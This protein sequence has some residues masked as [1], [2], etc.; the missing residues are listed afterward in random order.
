MWNQARPIASQFPIYAV[1]TRC[2]TLKCQPEVIF[3]ASY[4]NGHYTQGAFPTAISGVGGAMF[5]QQWHPWPLSGNRPSRSARR[6]PA[7]L[8]ISF[9]RRL[10]FEPLEDRRLLASV[11]VSNNLDVVNGNTSSI[12][13]LIANDGI[14]LREAIL[15]ANATSECVVW[16]TAHKRLAI[17]KTNCGWAI[18]HQIFVVTISSQKSRYK[19]Q[20]KLPGSYTGPEM[21]RCW[22]GCHRART[23]ARVTLRGQRRI[24]VRTAFG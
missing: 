4:V 10:R 20:R 12:A 5:P 24:T 19:S 2:E 21:R 3:V 15:A 13:A 1:A 6:R 9:H 22:L 14:S 17:G 8:L 7:D 18:S 11:A 23:L 16:R